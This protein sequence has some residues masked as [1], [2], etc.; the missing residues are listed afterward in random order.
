M[1]QHLQQQQQQQQLGEFEEANDNNADDSRFE[2]PTEAVAG[3]IAS[4]VVAS[5]VVA[6]D[7]INLV[8]SSTNATNYGDPFMSEMAV[9]NRIK[10]VLGGV[11]DT[12]F[13]NK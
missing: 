7:A 6:A 4:A 13:A 2:V 5:N 3:A 11:S 9:E 12:E 8:A 10:W 1:E